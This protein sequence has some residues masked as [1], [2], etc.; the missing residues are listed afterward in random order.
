MDHFSRAQIEKMLSV[1]WAMFV[2]TKLFI[3]DIVHKCNA[4]TEYWTGT[5]KPAVGKMSLN[6]KGLTTFNPS[7]KIYEVAAKTPGPEL[8]GEVEQVRTFFLV[9]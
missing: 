6:L 1:N 9:A 2:W 7:E 3:P 4:E 8:K 5:G